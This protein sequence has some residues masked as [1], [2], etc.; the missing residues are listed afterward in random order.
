MQV[1]GSYNYGIP[2]FWESTEG[3]L[4]GATIWEQAPGILG[5][6]DPYPIVDYHDDFLDISPATNTIP[7][8]TF[9]AATSGTIVQDTTN[10]NGA[11]TFSAG[12][13]TANQ[14]VNFQ[15][16]APS[17]KVA[18]SKP[19]FFEAYIKYT[20]LTNLKIQTFVG[21]AAASTAVISGGAMATLDRIGFQGITTTGVLTSVARGGGT[22]AT[23]TGVTIANSTFYRLGFVATSSLI[24]FYVNGLPVSTATTQIPTGA[25]C[26]TVVVQSNATDT[27]AASLDFIRVVG[28][29]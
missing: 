20:G 24:T 29:R 17:W 27:A 25:L 1:N 2:Y 22:A 23:G 10:P 5:P 13:A 12:A 28:L 19:V 3:P 15:F 26:P 18:A 8:W 6:V 14:G 7:G 11:L 21:L 16:N 9:T 4:P